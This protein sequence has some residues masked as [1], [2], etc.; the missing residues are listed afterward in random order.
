MTQNEKVLKYLTDNGS[1]T[2]LDA[3]REFGIM[4]LA[5]RV[6]DLKNMGYPIEKTMKAMKNRYGDKVR[7]AEYYFKE[8]KPE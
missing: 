6:A 1:I 7:F 5:S 2:P 3:Y 4:R 8:D